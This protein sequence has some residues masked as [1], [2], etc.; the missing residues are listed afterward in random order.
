MTDQPIREMLVSTF[1]RNF[2]VEA[3]AGSGKTTILVERLVQ[4]IVG[5]HAKI[6]ETAALT[7]TRKAAAEMRARFFL[8]LE[9]LARDTDDERTRKRLRE[10]LEQRHQ[11]YIGTIHGFCARLLHEYAVEANLPAMFQEIDPEAEEELRRQAWEAWVIRC[12]ETDQTQKRKGETSL[13]VTAHSWR[14]RLREVGLNVEDLRREFDTLCNYSDVTDWPA[15]EVTCPD[16]SGLAQELNEYHAHMRTLAPQL[17]PKVPDKLMAAYRRLPRLA[18]LQPVSP[19]ADQFFRF[20]DHYKPLK[21]NDVKASKWP[22]KLAQS[23]S[24]AKRWNDFC[25][26]KVMPLLH[27]WRAHRYPLVIS[28]LKE[29]AA[30]Y[31][32]ERYRRGLLTFQDLLLNSVKLVKNNSAARKSIAQQWKRLLVDE[33]QDTDPLQAELLFLIT[34]DGRKSGKETGRK[35]EDVPQL[36]RP[37][38]LFLVGDP[39][40]SIYRFRRADIAVYE[41]VKSNWDNCGELVHLTANFR[42]QP[43]LVRWINSTFTELFKTYPVPYQAVFVPMEPGRGDEKIPGSL[44]I[45]PI[46]SGTKENVA[47]NEAQVIA[48]F[49]HQS[50]Q[51]DDP[52][53]SGELS[54]DDFLI[55]TTQRNRLSAYSQALQ[56]WGIPHQ[57][58]GGAGLNE[59]PGLQLIKLLLAAATQPANESAVVGLLR[60]ELAGLS[61]ADLFEYQR[62]GGRFH[63]DSLPDNSS[64]HA[65]TIGNLFSHLQTLAGDLGSMSVSTALERT[66]I[67]LGVPV[68]SQEQ[69]ES[70][71][72]DLAAALMY[73]RGVESRAHTVQGVL[74]GLERLLS[75]ELRRDSL[76]VPS[77]A[78]TGVRIMNLHKAKGLEARVVI[79]ADSAVGRGIPP[80]TLHVERRGSISSG[81]LH[82]KKQLGPFQALSLAHPINWQQYEDEELKYLH[83][84]RCR[85]L[86]VAATRARDLLVVCS[87]TGENEDPN[88]RNPWADLLSF[89]S[90]ARRLEVQTQNDG[91][92]LQQKRPKEA[93]VPSTSLQPLSSAVNAW[94]T[95]LAPTVQLPSHTEINQ[96]SHLHNWAEEWQS[97][98]N[99]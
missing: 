73:L 54:V 75:R 13:F 30:Y 58:T 32:Q 16:Y 17:P 25:E 72:N 81:H 95:C 93:D 97:N 39:Q 74:T 90:G 67:K 36:P 53:L 11:T 37:G 6:Q 56:R 38:S 55:L 22:G 85:L 46:Q 66:L 47:E 71:L 64:A 15:A 21:K 29:S 76:F 41:Q 2:L 8:R 5:G 59:F 31:E 26:H 45:L 34:G 43:S 27:A 19:T 92:G 77:Q 57:I 20:L 82:L 4:M 79:L 87:L 9:Q 89:A 14:S 60:S 62:S 98:S 51:A 40:Q 52:G 69:N 42:A 96:S 86:Y 3:S 65:E 18:A 80:P 23:R 83:A 35:A 99:P 63:W 1:D 50:I 49:I 48:R 33:F 78:G 44:R 7:F 91:P 24:E 10:A 70:G 28:F 12:D 61:D 84:E 88:R 68:W 94:S